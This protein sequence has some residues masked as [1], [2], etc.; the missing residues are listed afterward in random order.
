M[1]IASTAVELTL[2]EFA[3]QWPYALRLSRRVGDAVLNGAMPE[4][5][6]L[7]IEMRAQSEA[8]ELLATWDERHRRQKL[9][10][11]ELDPLREK[12]EPQLRK[13]AVDEVR[14]KIRGKVKA[15]YRALA[16]RLGKFF[17]VQ[18]AEECRKG[19]TV[20]A[21]HPDHRTLETLT[22]SDILDGM[23]DVGDNV[24]F[25]KGQKWDSVSVSL[26][27]ADATTRPTPRSNAA[28]ATN[29]AGTDDLLD[30]P[31]GKSPT[32]AA[33]IGFIST[34]TAIVEAIAGRLDLLDAL[35]G[36][37]QKAIVDRR[38]VP[39]LGRMIDGE[40]AT[41]D[42]S[43]WKKPLGFESISDG[44]VNHLALEPADMRLANALLYFKQ[45]KWNPWIAAWKARQFK[46]SE[47]EPPA[48][49]EEI[50]AWAQGEMV[51]RA[52]SGE[53]KD[54]DTMVLA[55][56]HRFSVKREIALSVWADIPEK[57]KGRRGRRS[58]TERISGQK[59]ETPIQN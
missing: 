56:K 52:K 49:R 35:L 9:Q 42:P 25:S 2:V 44:A 23:V 8:N 31:F 45:S 6:L 16:E 57:L 20:R 28:N 54:R 18:L 32:E 27:V 10:L 12:H 46:K 58:S 30:H 13:L 38:L 37:L 50:M 33:P 34:K 59:Q 26:P 17:A 55:I 24:L 39:E 22:R 11:R 4:C 21:R 3:S 40:R 51:S 41:L 48:S 5:V 36:D 1:S 53:P 29:E 19:A 15:R 14:A 43:F 7:G 47:T